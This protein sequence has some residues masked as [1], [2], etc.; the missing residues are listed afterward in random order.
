MNP[1]LSVPWGAPS[2]LAFDSRRAAATAT[3]VTVT[4]SWGQLGRRCRQRRAGSVRVEC[5]CGAFISRG[6]WRERLVVSPGFPDS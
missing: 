2:A 1:A 4:N 5:R 3:T 6:R